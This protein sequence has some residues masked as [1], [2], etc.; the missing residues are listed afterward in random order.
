M[1]FV[2]SYARY[3]RLGF[4]A[5]QALDFA[6][7]RP[8]V[9]PILAALASREER[10]GRRRAQLRV[11]QMNVASGLPRHDRGRPALQ[12][13][14]GVRKKTAAGVDVANKVSSL[15]VPWGF[16]ADGRRHSPQQRK[17]GDL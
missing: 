4:T 3:R 11:V 9:T 2:L 5:R 13:V 7:S 6:L 16:G 17:E 8:G 12:A 15:P 1:G 14:S 10:A